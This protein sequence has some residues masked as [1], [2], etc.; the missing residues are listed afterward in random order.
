M[1]TVQSPVICF[2]GTFFCL[3]VLAVEWSLFFFE[4]GLASLALFVECRLRSPTV[5]ARASFHLF[6]LCKVGLSSF[7]Y[8][9]ASPSSFASLCLSAG[10]RMQA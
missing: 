6:M 3:S 7:C 5:V 10:C 8:F 9:Y 4:F 2:R 1:T